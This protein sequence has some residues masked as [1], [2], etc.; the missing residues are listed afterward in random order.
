MTDSFAGQ[1]PTLEEKVKHLDTKIL[2]AQTEL[3][4]RELWLE[5]T[6]ESN[7]GYQSLNTWLTKK[8]ET[9]LPFLLSP[10]TCNSLIILVILL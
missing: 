5:Q 6:T 8:L 9:K 2:D 7:D 10:G 1:I 4:T 3:R